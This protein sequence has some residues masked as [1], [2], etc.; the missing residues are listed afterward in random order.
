MVK[1]PLVSI[2]TVVFNGAKHL[3]QTILSVIGQSY[4][5]IEYIII[6][7]GS[8]DG[9]LNIIKEYEHKIAYWKS[10]KDNGISDGFNKGIRQANGEIIG[11][12]NSDD[13]YEPDTVRRIVEQIDGC[14]VLYGDLQL[15]K[16][17]EKE[18]IFEGNHAFLNHEMCVNHPTVFV[19]RE[20]YNNY[21]NFSSAYKYAMDYD[22]LL[23]V[24]V[25]DVRFKRVTGVL[26][27]MRWSGVSDTNWLQ[28]CIETREIKNKYIPGNRK[29][30]KAYFFKHVLAI[31]AGKLLRKLGLETLIRMY[32]KLSKVKKY[33]QE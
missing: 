23:R 8:T 28:G 31:Y 13:W 21:G 20:L 25:K 26:A 10:E 14:D 6:D 33:H 3:R 27:N 19:R 5:N 9:T 11:I 24:K 18:Y 1:E 22:F 12:I 29:A 30:H 32:R 7:G 2:I 17:N 15:W 4:T 16:D